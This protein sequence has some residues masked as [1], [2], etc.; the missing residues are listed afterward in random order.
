M[1]L[2]L[3]DMI[4]HGEDVI[5]GA[6]LRIGRNMLGH[7]RRRE[8]ARIEG[9]RAIALAEMAHLRLPAAPIAG[10]FMNEDHGVT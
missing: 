9:D 4:E 6:G 7:V 1:R 3:A 10:E 2:S 8:T 5:G